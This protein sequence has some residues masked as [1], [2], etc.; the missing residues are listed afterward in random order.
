MT[1]GIILVDIPESCEKCDYRGYRSPERGQWC[2][3]KSEHNNNET[4]PDWC[5]IKPMP[6]KIIYKSRQG[7]LQEQIALGWN[8][9][10]DDILGGENG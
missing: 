9:C 2:V 7:L 8:A 4:K 10:I 6:E 5:P 3:L 1:K